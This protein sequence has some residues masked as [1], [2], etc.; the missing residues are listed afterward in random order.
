M[1]PK[2][3]EGLLTNGFGFYIIP[4]LEVFEECINA[5]NLVEEER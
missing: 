2:P 1:H 3:P 4:C 5:V